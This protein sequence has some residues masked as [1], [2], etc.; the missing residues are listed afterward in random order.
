MSTEFLTVTE[1][2]PYDAERA[3]AIS[4]AMQAWDQ[5]LGLR[6]HEGQEQL[7]KLLM[8]EGMVRAHYDMDKEAR[9]SSEDEVVVMRREIR[10][11]C[12]LLGTTSACALPSRTSMSR[13]FEQKIGERT[14]H[15]QF[16]F[17]QWFV[18][19]NRNRRNI[20]PT[21]KPLSR[22]TASEGTCPSLENSS[23]SEEGWSVID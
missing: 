21:E 12:V 7:C 4:V 16:R 20:A 18:F 2:V 9:A 17:D 11:L 5:E 19:Y 8:L 3:R 13:Y 23:C 22:T 6:H 15:E 1:D 10:E 14:H